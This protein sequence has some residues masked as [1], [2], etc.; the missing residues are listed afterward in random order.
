MTRPLERII[1]SLSAL[2]IGT[3]ESVSPGEIKVL[4]ELEAPQATALNTGVPL[5][6]PRI[7]NYVL[8][9]NEVGAVV[10]MIVWLGVERSSFPKRKGLKDFDIIDLPFPL[11][12]L[13]LTPVGT[14]IP[15]DEPGEGAAEDDSIPLRLDRGVTAFP[16]VGDPVL[17]PTP[18]QLR[19]V[20]EASGRDRRI[21][22]G[23][24]PMAGG[25][26]ITADPDKLFGRHLAVLGNTGSGKSCTVAGLVRWSLEAAK[27][28]VE[29]AREQTCENLEQTTANARFIILD[30]N[31]EYESAFP[32]LTPRVFRVSAPGMLIRSVRTEQ[33]ADQPTSAVELP[34]EVPAWLWNSH[35]W[36]AFA[37]ASERT[38]RPLLMRALRE[39]R[40]SGTP[41]VGDADEV[42]LARHFRLRL[43]QVE[44]FF[45]QGP[46]FWGG[47]AGKN[48]IGQNIRSI[49]NEAQQ[50]LNAHHDLDDRVKKALELVRDSAN[51]LIRR[52]PERNGFFP[53]WDRFDFQPV[54]NSLSGLWALF[55]HDAPQDRYTEDT[56][57]YFDITKLPDHLELLA[58]KEGGNTPQHIA[59]MTTRIRTMLQDQRLRPIIE[60]SGETR[61]RDWLEQ[62][63]GANQATNGEVAI[64]DLALVPSDVIHI[65]IAVI[66]R[67][68][69]E[70]AQRH[71]KLNQETLPTV[72]V[73]EE[74]HTF[75]SRHVAFDTEV[76]SAA[77][78]CRQTFERIA[79]EGRKFGLGLVLS[80]Q[81]PSELSQTA[82][83]QCNTYILHRVV[84]D[85]DQKLLGRLVP[86][87]LGGLLKEL[88][89]LPS[90]RAILLGWATPI[91]TLVDINKLSQDHQPRSK[92][93]DF[94][95]VWT[96]KVTRPIDW[97]AVAQD[98]LNAPPTDTDTEAIADEPADSS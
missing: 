57:A 30:P 5:G 60:P 38:Q 47:T 1:E 22:I 9:P 4:L 85:D 72:L 75:I 69:F 2:T 71:V 97:E 15:N 63:V 98:W 39:L 76:T 61:L 45:E 87:A 80:S 59:T 28:E 68:V 93:P 19:S 7:N 21:K 8:I 58:S 86:D 46:Q 33:P 16:S 78:M 95:D 13:G 90:R 83:A 77:Q 41:S 32:D 96:L 89:S 70:A 26:T 11:R 35:E 53:A 18:T 23:T 36:A 14:L 67:I 52:K 88:S 27:V 49:G 6:F 94:W 40:S 62:Y 51:D 79:R 20:I 37:A 48:E 74:A 24:S 66:A 56:P 17:L 91:P 55:P 10:G 65:V 29:R 50:F 42:E 12:K 73:L 81:R 54:L 44:S 92:D 43:T 82:L 31:G 34:L 25:T 84:N 3:V 64:I